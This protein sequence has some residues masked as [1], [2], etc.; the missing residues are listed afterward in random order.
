LPQ[1]LQAGSIRQ[2]SVWPFPFPCDDQESSVTIGSDEFQRLSIFFVFVA[3]LPVEI[4]KDVTTRVVRAVCARATAS[5]LADAADF[6][7][8]SSFGDIPSARF[9]T[10]RATWASAVSH[11]S[12]CSAESAATADFMS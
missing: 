12:A 2:T 1:S 6:Y 3:G 8:A 9:I 5:Q 4:L 11:L 7:L 10:R